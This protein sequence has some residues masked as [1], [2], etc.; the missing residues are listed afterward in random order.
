M[1]YADGYVGESGVLH[2]GAKFLK[3]DGDGTAVEKP[4][5]NQGGVK[6]MLLRNL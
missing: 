2:P 3:Q 6:E 4:K 1:C 5:A